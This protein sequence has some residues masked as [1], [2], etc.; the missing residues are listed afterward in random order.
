MP[1]RPDAARDDDAD[2]G[3]V[4]VV[5]RRGIGDRGQQRVVVVRDLERD[6]A[7]RS[8][9]AVA[10]GR[11]AGTGGRCAGGCPRRRRRRTAVRGPRRR[12]RRRPDRPPRRPS[13][14]SG[15][16]GSQGSEES[17]DVQS[18]SHAD[19]RHHLC[20]RPP[21]HRRARHRRRRRDRRRDGRRGPARGHRA[22]GARGAAHARQRRPRRSPPAPTG[23]SRTTRTSSCWCARRV[24][25]MRDFADYTGQTRYDAGL[26]R[27]RP[28]VVTTTEEGAAA[29]RETAAHHASL[30]VDGIELL[31]GDEARR[32]FPV[33]H[34]GRAAD[35]LP[36]RRR[37][38]EP[39][40]AR[41]G[42]AGGLARAGRQPAAACSA[43][44][45]PAASWW[46][47][48]RRAARSRRAAA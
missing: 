18:Y 20:G 10:G 27:Q 34:A 44:I 26:R 17:S 39:E 31:D 1:G 38:D 6:R 19:R 13:R 45:S 5:R 12:R 35:P 37:G 42:P 3:L 33:A 32:A 48:G 23:C 28:R 21:G 2:V 46:P 47:C 8:V 36:R 43:S 29:Q 14:S 16:A 22:A 9:Q 30:G 25:A 7:G 41:A 15:S 40:A 11:T 4:D 24:A